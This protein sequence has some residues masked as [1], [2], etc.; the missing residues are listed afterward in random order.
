[1]RIE[2]QRLDWLFFSEEIT[3][4][5][6][7]YEGG[8]PLELRVYAPD[9]QLVFSDY[10]YSPVLSFGRQFLP[11]GQYAYRIRAGNREVS[12]GELGVP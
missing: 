7:R 6:E 9:G 10:F 4:V 11:D 12:R 5:L 1:M 2:E 3:I 8:Y